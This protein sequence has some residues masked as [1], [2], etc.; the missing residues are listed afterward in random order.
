[1]STVEVA[2]DLKNV[3]SHLIASTSEIMAYGMPYDKI[4][5]YLIGNIDYEKVCDGF[6]SFYSNYVTPCGTIGVTDCSELDNLAAIMKEINQRYT[7][8]EELTGELQRLDGYTPTIFFDYGDYVSKLCSDPDLLEQF[9]EQLKRAVPFKRNTEQYFTAISSS[10]YGEKLISILSPESR[11][12]TQALIR[13]LQKR[14]KQRGILPL[15]KSTLRSI[16]W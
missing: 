7:F 6:Y 12:P 8:N 13:V 3:T 9:N 10:Y 4:G 14:T 2:Y 11:F 15:I 1:M 5:Q 16:R